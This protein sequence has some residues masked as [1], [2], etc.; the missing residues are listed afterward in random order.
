MRDGPMID[1]LMRGGSMKRAIALSLLSAV[2][3]AASFAPAGLWPLAWAAFVPLFYAIECSLRSNLSSDLSARK[4]F[5]RIFF[6]GWAFGFFF[7]LLTVYWVAHSMYSFGGVPVAVSVGVMLLLVAYLAIYPGLFALGFV[8]SRCFSPVLRLIFLSSLWVALEFLRGTLFTGFPWVLT[9][10]SQANFPLLIQ[11]ADLFGPYGISF[12]IMAVNVAIFLFI[13]A[14]KRGLRGTRYSSVCVLVLV[15]FII[16]YALV[17]YDEYMKDTGPKGIIEASVI[18]GNIDQSVKW[19]GSFKGD[20]VSIYEELTKEAA[21]DGASL[22]VWPETAMPFYMRYDVEFGP[23]VSRIARESGA[24]LIAGSP[25]YEIESRD[26]RY[27]NSAFLLTPSGKVTGRYDKIKLVPFG[28]YIPLK[29]VLFFI[30]KLTEGVGDFS[31]GKSYDPLR[32]ESG[33][34]SYGLLICFESIFPRIAAATARSGATLLVVMTNDG[35]FGR[36]SAPFQ[37][38]DMA[39]F[40]A[41]ENRLFLIRSANTGVS[42]FIDPNGRVLNKTEIFTT[43]TINGMVRNLKHPPTFFARNLYLMPLVTLIIS[44]LFIFIGIKRRKVS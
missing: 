5:L 18:Q 33:D 19:D 43:G 6:T 26:I 9:A 2:L 42:G 38:F 24:T 40:R 28:E 23:E 12:V 11:T 21:K 29:K 35:W 13:A 39:R 7:F 15:A 31:S 20:T 44:G 8:L 22:I 37:H 32:T 41:V 10:Y 1:G 27:Y 4:K 25:H 14:R 30:N 17:R 3:L 36:T 16:V 34:G